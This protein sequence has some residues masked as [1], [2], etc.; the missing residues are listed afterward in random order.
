M[1]VN[2]KAIDVSEEVGKVLASAL[3]LIF[4]VCTGKHI[5]KLNDT[6][7]YNAVMAI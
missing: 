3:P 4:S 6:N 2:S 5:F 1:N 7:N